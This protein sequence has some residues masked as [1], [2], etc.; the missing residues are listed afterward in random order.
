MA[1]FSKADVE[2]I[3]SR[4]MVRMIKQLG[5]AELDDVATI[6]AEE[7]GSDTPVAEQL[8]VVI[9]KRIAAALQG[10]DSEDL[11]VVVPGICD[12]ADG[13]HHCITVCAVDAIQKGPDGTAFI[14]RDRCIDC[15]FCV[16]ACGSGALVERSQCLQ[17]AEML[18]QRRQPQLYAIVAPAFVAQFGPDV[19][20]VQVKA[21]ILRL[22]F[23][24]VYEVAMAADVL[25]VLEADEFLQR[26]EAGET[27]MITSCC[28]PAF[29]KLVEKH[30]PLV[31]HLI[32]ETVSPMVALGRMLKSREPGCHVVFIGPCL[33]KRAESKRPELANAIDSVLTFKE[34]VTLFE[35]AGVSLGEQPDGDVAAFC[36]ASHDGRIYAHTGGVTAAVQRAIRE[37][38]PEVPFR[39]LKGNGLKQ[40][41]QILQAV[42]AGEA[43]GNFMEGMACPGGCVG[44]PGTCV[45]VEVGASGVQAFAKQAHVQAARKN[46]LAD[47]WVEEATRVSIFYSDKQGDHV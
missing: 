38:N 27:F 34:L 19:S 1:E 20:P 3:T 36:E 47:R 14:D 40:C 44:G 18:S 21:A 8:K 11:V 41:S 5:N 12:C 33:A 25:T 13:E 32:S 6:I 10:V 29:I 4:V 15:G 43:D 42:E 39:P 45:P 24:D 26:N 2:Q 22:G 46:K 31:S 30:R 23:S 37:K 35:A 9:G 28:C 16:D 7:V 17:I